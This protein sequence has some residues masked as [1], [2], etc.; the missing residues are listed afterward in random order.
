MLQIMANTSTSLLEVEKNLNHPSLH[1]HFIERV[2]FHFLEAHEMSP[3]FSAFQS[4]FKTIPLNA[5]DDSLRIIF[6]S[7]MHILLYNNFQT[8]TLWSLTRENS[9]AS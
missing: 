3:V 7:Y 4:V 2:V 8:V 5:T 6:F 9:Q 1:L